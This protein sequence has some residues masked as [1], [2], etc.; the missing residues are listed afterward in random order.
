MGSDF[1]FFSLYPYIQLQ[2]PLQLPCYAFISVSNPHFKRITKVYTLIQM[3]T[4]NPISYELNPKTQRAVCTK[5][6]YL[7]NA[8]IK[9][10]TCDSV[11]I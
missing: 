6:Q 9:A 11:F 4:F 2:V 10:F 3:Y 7:F 5:F 1:F 8:I